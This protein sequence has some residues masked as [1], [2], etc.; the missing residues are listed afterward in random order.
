[1]AMQVP[2]NVDPEQI[3]SVCIYGFLIEKIYIKFI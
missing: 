2:T 3:K 1:M